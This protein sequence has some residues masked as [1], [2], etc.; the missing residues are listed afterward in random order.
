MIAANI[1]RIVADE[2]EGEEKADGIELESLSGLLPGFLEGEVFTGEDRKE[3]IK[4]L[5]LELAKQIRSGKLTDKS[6][7]F[8]FLKSDLKSKL[9]WWIY[10][11][12]IRILCACN[13]NN[14]WNRL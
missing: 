3:A 14:C 2:I 10:W 4:S 11:R 5:R 7:V 9:N 13:I 6:K 12:Q 1:A 8:E